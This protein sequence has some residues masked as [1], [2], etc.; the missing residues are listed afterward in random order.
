MLTD[1]DPTVEVDMAQL[2]AKTTLDVIAKVAFGVD[3]SQGMDNSRA[4]YMA[5]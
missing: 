2:L 3:F 4:G 5:E 1:K